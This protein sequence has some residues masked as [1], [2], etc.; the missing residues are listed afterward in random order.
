MSKENRLAFL[1]DGFNVYHS[2]I[3]LERNRGFRSKW[4]DLYKLC[5]SY[6]HLF[7]KEARLKSVYYFSAIALHLQ[8]ENPGRIKRHRIYIKCL[9]DSGVKIELARFKKKSVY[10]KECSKRFT[11]YEEKETDV[12]IAVKVFELFSKNLY[13]TIIIMSG[14]TDLSPVI[15]SCK[16]IFPDKE[17]VFAFPYARKNKELIKLAPKSFSVNPKTYLKHQFPNSYVLSNGQKIFKPKN[18]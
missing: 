10:C 8:N 16:N 17:V 7:G 11:A 4:L 6:S 9:E 1:I 14:D 3:E 2:I 15:Q 18:W 12:A 13:D 5:D